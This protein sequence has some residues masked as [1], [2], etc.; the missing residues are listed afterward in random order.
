[1]AAEGA[2]SPSR[3]GG[4]RR[5]GAASRPSRA[6]RLTAV[7]SR[8]A[9]QATAA[10]ITDW[11]KAGRSTDDG[12]GHEALGRRQE[13]RL[14]HGAAAHQLIDHEALAAE[15]G[16]APQFQ[17]GGGLQVGALVQAAQG[18]RAL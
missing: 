14:L 8:A 15:I 5:D 11:S 6:M 18:G 13:Q 10:P 16:A 9:A 4:V 7:R 12:R 3:P 1:M 2:G 17:R